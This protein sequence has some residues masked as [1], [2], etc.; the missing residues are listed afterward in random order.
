MD[1][2]SLRATEGSADEQSSGSVPSEPYTTEDLLWEPPEI[3]ASTTAPRTDWVVFGIAAALT[4]AFVAWGAV[5]PDSLAAIADRLLAG[6]MHYGGWGFVL[7]ASAF[8]LI[9]LWLAF[10]KYGRITLG[11]DDEPPQY[12]TLS[13]ISMLFATGMGIGLMFWGVSEPLAHFVTPPPGTAGGTTAETATTAMATT[14]FHW[15]LHPWAIY[16]VVGLAI[17]YGTYRRGRRQLI[18]AAFIPLIGER[19]A[20]GPVGKLIDV[21]AIFATLFGSAC[22]LGLGALQIAGGFQQ[23]GWVATIGIG[24]LIGIIAALALCF[25]LSAVSGIDKGIQWLSN[26]NMGM[27]ALLLLFLLVVGPTVYILNMIPNMLG[28]YLQDFFTMAARSEAS[29]GPGTAEWLSGWTVFYWAWWISWTPFV[30]LFI[31]KI[32]RGRTIRQF[33]AGVILVP[34]V[35]SLVWFAILGGT[36]IDLQTSGVDLAGEA[37][38]EAQLFSLLENFPWATVVSVAVAVLIAVFFITGAD[39]ASIVMGTL[40]QRGANDPGKLMTVFWGVLIAAVAAIMLMVG[41]TDG[42]ALDGLQNLTILVA[43][44]WTI[45]MILLCVALVR[46]LRRDP[47]I[48]RSHKANEVVTAA[49]VA[50]A[51]DYDGDFQIEISPAEDCGVNVT[52]TE[53]GGG[54]ADPASGTG[55]SAG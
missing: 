30:G 14:M 27:A 23:L 9:A 48:V 20:N 40:S 8:V 19:H 21:L 42:N 43:A 15:S 33:V 36:A 24:L 35:V 13:W 29:G 16:A 4:L 54:D 22:S 17:A 32:S 53:R 38:Q 5:S 3:T 7:S 52:V 51:Q 47:L 11:R 2:N 1:H 18:S 45:V 25:V 6:L 46:D 41:G 10:S 12:N 39:S 50:G 44:P 37:N 28:G 34:S 31:G 26:A 49:V 55:K